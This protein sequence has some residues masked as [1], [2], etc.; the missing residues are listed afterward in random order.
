MEQA[1]AMR[2][3]NL[4]AAAVQACFYALYEDETA[5]FPPE[6]AFAPVKFKKISGA[7]AALIQKHTGW[8]S[9]HIEAPDPVFG[10]LPARMTFHVK[11]EFLQ[12]WKQ[13]V[14]SAL[15]QTYGQLQAVLQED[16][17]ESAQLVQGGQPAAN[18][19]N[20]GLTPELR[21]KMQE[22]IAENIRKSGSQPVDP[23]ADSETL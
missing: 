6:A 23:T 10:W 9:V 2:V 4:L 5:P 17:E 7:G 12:Q 1:E 11:P 19:P 8:A 13:I 22:Q 21:Q 15:S 18:E 20:D 3:A 16:A 14:V